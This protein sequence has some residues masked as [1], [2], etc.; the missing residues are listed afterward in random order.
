MVLKHKMYINGEWVES[1]SHETYTRVNP[2]DPSEVLGEFQKGNASDA[3][4]AIEAAESAFE[5][6]SE[7]PPPKRAEHLL[8]AAQMLRDRKE[9]LA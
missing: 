1:E 7:T 2:A 3:E 8:R 9:E 4:K 5:K 6:W